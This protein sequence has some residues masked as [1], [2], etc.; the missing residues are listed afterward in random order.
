MDIKVMSISDYEQVHKLWSS[1]KGVGLSYPD[2]S[3]E[4]IAKFLSRNPNTCFVAEDGQEMI[5]TIL[6]GNDGRRGYIYHT[7]VAP[8]H[9]GQ[10]IARKLVDAAAEALRAEGIRKAALVVFSDN[11][12]G[13]AFWEKAGF[14]VRDDLLYRNMVLE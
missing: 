6:A 8:S 3:Q 13:N 7:A 4:G 12:G 5:G 2:D 11:S 1:C 14:T 10:G 9:R